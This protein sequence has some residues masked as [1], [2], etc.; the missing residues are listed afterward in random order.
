MN[1]PETSR[2][3]DHDYPATTV[4]F[5]IDRS[6]KNSDTRQ[7]YLITHRPHLDPKS[8]V[9]ESSCSVEW[10]MSRIKSVESEIYYLT[11][12]NPA[13]ALIKHSSNRTL[14]PGSDSEHPQ[15][16]TSKSDLHVN[17]DH[18]G[19]IFAVYLTIVAVMTHPLAPEA[20]IYD[21]ISTAVDLRG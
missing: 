2:R 20:Q 1:D 12:A 8:K 13:W 16:C 17:N 5:L 14:C 4:I 7:S 19:T 15:P 18:H 11:H 6:I 21:C 3:T 10:S 9:K